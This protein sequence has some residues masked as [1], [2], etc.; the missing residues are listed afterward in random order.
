MAR[1][2]LFH[3]LRSLRSRPADSPP[4]LATML[5]YP[6]SHAIKREVLS[7]VCCGQVRILRLH[8][9]G[10]AQFVSMSYNEWI[11]YG[12]AAVERERAQATCVPANLAKSS[13][14][15]DASAETVAL[16][17]A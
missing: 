5:R 17:G 9:S 8:C 1:L 12:A 6:R 15:G 4:A 3:R 14:G 11:A 10:Q 7:S 16:D 2:R 13:L